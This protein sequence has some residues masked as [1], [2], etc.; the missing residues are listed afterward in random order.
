MIKVLNGKIFYKMVCE[1]NTEFE[2][3]LVEFLQKNNVSENEISKLNIPFEQDKTKI[4]GNDFKI[5]IHY[6][7]KDVVLL[8]ETML[9]TDEFTEFVKGYFE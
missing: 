9:T 2:N 8:F 5:N 6:R 7:E 3:T 4:E 1:K